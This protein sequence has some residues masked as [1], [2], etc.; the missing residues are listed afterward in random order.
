MI[1]Y[2]QEDGLLNGIRWDLVQNGAFPAWDRRGKARFSSEAE[3]IRTKNA[4]AQTTFQCGWKCPVKI[5]ST[6]ARRL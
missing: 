2:A 5:T 3:G 6:C 1:M 4:K